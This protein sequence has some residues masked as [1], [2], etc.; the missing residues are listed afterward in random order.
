MNQTEAVTHPGISDSARSP[1][2]D[3]AQEMPG[4]GESGNRPPAKVFTVEA[5]YDYAYVQHS[6][7]RLGC[8]HPPHDLF[9]RGAMEHFARRLGGAAESGCGPGTRGT[10]VP[11]ECKPRVVCRRVWCVVSDPVN[12][13]PADKGRLRRQRK[14]LADLGRRFGFTML[15]VS[16]DWHGFHLSEEDRRNSTSETERQW[17]PEDKGTDV[18][19]AL[20][21]QRRAEAPD[22]PDGLLMVTGDADVAP[23]LQQIQKLGLAVRVVVA[24]FEHSLSRVYMRNSPV[25]YAWQGG[26]IILDSYLPPRGRNEKGTPASCR[27]DSVGEC[28]RT[29]EETTMSS[30]NGARDVAK[31]AGQHGTAPK[32]HSADPD[33]GRIVAAC[34]KRGELQVYRKVD[35]LMG[36]RV[37]CEDDGGKYGVSPGVRK[38]FP[39]VGTYRG[40]AYVDEG[41][42]LVFKFVAGDTSAARE[43]ILTISAA[44]GRVYV[45]GSLVRGKSLEHG[46]LVAFHWRLENGNGDGKARRRAES[47]YPLDGDHLPLI[48]RLIA[49]G[50]LVF[51]AHAGALDAFLGG[52]ASGDVPPQDAGRFKTALDRL[53]DDPG[54]PSNLQMMARAERARLVSGGPETP[55]LTAPQAPPAVTPDGKTRGKTRRA[56]KPGGYNPATGDVSSLDLQVD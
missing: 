46:T 41:R 23:A 27:T 35:G 17:K 13:H 2:N 3:L 18:T 51:P 14:W 52:L 5:V 10:A 55:A 9:V 38:Q 16:V 12:V 39:N 4:S 50:K 31:K 6:A 25:G 29:V 28:A 44:F 40:L 33:V 19:M 30:T 32:N 42:G 15:P 1:D 7:R 11:A 43:A 21:L 48:A 36:A 49:N 45:P 24:G 37:F 47:L 20:H 56:G 53:A 26:P 22:H 8:R 54:V 34:P